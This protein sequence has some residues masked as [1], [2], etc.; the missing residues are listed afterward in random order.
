VAWKTAAKMKQVDLQNCTREQFEEVV[1][2]LFYG[3]Y[4]AWAFYFLSSSSDEKTKSS[5]K[6]EANNE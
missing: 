3:L 6:R 1:V 5:E 2:E 4:V